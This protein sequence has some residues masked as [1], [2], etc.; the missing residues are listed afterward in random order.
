MLPPAGPVF[1]VR[2]LA[3]EQMYVAYFPPGDR[4]GSL[5]GYSC[6]TLDITS[7]IETTD[8]CVARSIVA[9]FLFGLLCVA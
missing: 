3:Y 9:F 1:N 6:F 8:L 4:A 2:A 5:V 7:S